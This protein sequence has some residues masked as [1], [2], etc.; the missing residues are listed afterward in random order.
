MEEKP[1][2]RKEWNSENW[3]CLGLVF[4]DIKLTKEWNDQRMGI[5]KSFAQAIPALSH[6]GLKNGT[7]LGTFFRECDVR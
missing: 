3:Y 7:L 1:R 5:I 2:A 6:S 4:F